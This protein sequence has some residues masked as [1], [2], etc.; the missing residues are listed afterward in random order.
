MPSALLATFQN[1]PALLAQGSEQQFEAFLSKADVDLARIESANDNPVMAD[2]FWFAPDDWRAA[3]RPYVVKDGMLFIPVK[4]V[5][6]HDFGYQLGSWATGYTY[7]ARALRRGL[8]DPEVRGIAFMINS[9][10][11]HVAG[12]FD[13]VDEIFAARGTKPMRAFAYEGAYSAA[14]SIASAASSIA[15]PRTGGVGSIGV[16]TVHV[17]ISKMMDE[18]GVKITY[19]HA[20]KHKV[21]GNPYEPLPDN[22]KARIQ[23]RIDALYDV[24]VSTVARNRGMDEQAVRDTEALTFS[25]Q[26]ATSNGLADSIGSLDDAIA[27]F[28]ADMSNQE[29]ENMTTQDKSAVDQAAIDTARTQGFEAGKA[30]GLK[31]GARAEKDRINTIMDSEEGKKRP[32]AARAAA[33]GT[34][35]T[36]DEALAFLATLDEEGPAAT[37]VDPKAPK[38]KEGAAADFMAAMNSTG[39]P[40]LGNPGSEAEA[41]QLTRAERAMRSAGYKPKSAA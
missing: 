5:L 23:E 21:D 27:V 8:A 3:Y 28:A 7:I 15:M 9:P 31:D 26:E 37:A 1:E 2:D 17:D 34:N 39:N 14:Y 20:G 40:E 4:G 33:L 13:L 16:L 30:E 35:M 22:V 11:G 36:A 19:I 18:A 12:N 29:D 25:A 6:L 32:K 38:G 24:F 41:P 10:G